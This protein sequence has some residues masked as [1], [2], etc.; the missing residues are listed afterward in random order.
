MTVIRELVEKNRTYRRF[1]ETEIIAEAQLREWVDL[2]RITSSGMN[3]QP[4]KYIL[5]WEPERNSRIFP[6]LRWAGYLKEWNGPEPGERP[7]AYIVMLGD[8]AVSKNVWWD[9][10]LACQSIL[11]AA[12]EE[13]YGGCM[14]GSIDREALR[15]VLDLD[16]QYE[17]LLV[18]A[19]GKPV[20]KVVL[21]PL[22]P[23]GDI[24]YY[25]DKDQIH[26]VPKRSLDDII[27]NK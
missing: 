6:H 8:T 24:K 19:L 13:G 18:I 9:H 12:V 5:S 10:G 20:E 25:R 3:N 16:E 2:A 11:L 15:K 4:L 23:D 21:E 14:F 27:L 7:A 22:K 26:H 17:I 1:A